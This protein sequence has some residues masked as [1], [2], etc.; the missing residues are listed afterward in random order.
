MFSSFI[1]IMMGIR[2]LEVINLEFILRFKI[3]RNDW[4]PADMCPQAAIHCALF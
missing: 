1:I 3:K 4:L 2:D